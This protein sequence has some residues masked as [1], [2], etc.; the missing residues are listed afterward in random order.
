MDGQRS[1]RPALELAKGVQSSTRAYFGD[2]ATGFGVKNLIEDPA[3][4]AFSLAFEAY[5]F[6]PVIFNY[7][8]GFFAFAVDYGSRSVLIEPRGEEWASFDEFDRV[9]QQ[10]DNELRL[11]I[12]DKYLDAKGW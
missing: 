12:P 5:E 6:V 9:L 2:R 11:R 10:L 3:H 8:R 7:D 4:L 1:D